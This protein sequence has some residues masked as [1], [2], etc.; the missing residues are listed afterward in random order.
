MK[1]HPI[2]CRLLLLAL[3]VISLSGCV[4]NRWRSAYQAAY[5]AR[6]EGV[7][8]P[9]DTDVRAL[10]VQE[11]EK[12]DQPVSRVWEA[13]LTLAT[14]TCSLLGVQD[15]PG[16]G[17]R[18]LIA[19]Y[20]SVRGFDVL[21]DRWLAVSIQP[22]DERFTRVSIALVSPETARVMPLASDPATFDLGGE[23]S[24]SLGLAASADLLLAINQSFT[25]PAYLRVLG[26]LRPGEPRGPA[27][28]PEIESHPQVD[29]LA[30]RHGNYSS[31]LYRRESFILHFPELERRLDDLAHRLAMAADHPGSEIRVYLVADRELD[32][33][34]E[35]NGDLFLS[36][37]TLDA[38]ANA[39]ELAGIMA[40]EMAHFYLNHGRTRS[41]GVRAAFLSQS[42]VAIAAET[43]GFAFG[44]YLPSIPKSPA[45]KDTLWTPKQ[46]LVGT[47][48]A[49]AA[50]SGGV[51]FGMFAGTGLAR[52]EI[53]QFSQSEEL[54]ADD[55]GTELLW[56]AGFDYHGLLN[57]L[58][59]TGHD[60]GTAR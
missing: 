42:S 29:L 7:E 15:D 1:R 41:R 25:E 40:H 3:A 49:I 27:L 58:Q 56:R 17:H 54:A 21:V 43:A 52:A 35:A 2:R 28:R 20:H 8:V 45:P 10:N 26:E 60:L 13:F 33:H 47:V 32:A 37:G 9:A 23:R 51:Y 22:V 34:I 12:L 48:V 30:E 57:L 44:V 24:R 36:S 39:D 19:A 18:A 53:H 4:Q 5:L 46:I 11:E 14:E 6:L 59:R 31:A 16:G 55:Y 38:V 50:V